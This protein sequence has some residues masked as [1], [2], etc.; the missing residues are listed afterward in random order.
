[1]RKIKSISEYFFSV[2]KILLF[3]LKIT[4]FKSSFYD[5]K[6]SNNLPSKFDYKPSFHI[7][8]SL[9]LF[10]KKKI[11]IENFSLNSL[12]KLST[13]KKVEFQNL[14]N[15]LWLTSLD[16]KTNKLS[17]QTIIENWIDNNYSFNEKTWKLDIISK[18]LI[19][20]ISSSNLTIDESS[21]NYKEKLL[22]S[23]TKQINHL[24]KNID[25]LEDDENKLICC[26]SLFLIGLTFKNQTKH[27]KLGL[28][29]LKKIIKNNFDDTRFPKSRNP[30]EMLICLKYL[31]L[32]KEWI[33]ESQNQIPDYLEEII[34]N[35]GKSYNF[36]SKNLNKLPLFNGSSEI[37]NDRFN[38]YLNYFNY[39]FKDNSK[40]K[41]GYVI[42]KNKKIVFIMDI[43][44]TPDFKHSKKYQS[45][46][47]SFEIT[48]N[49]EKLICNLGFDVNKDNKIKLLSKS[50]AAHSTL[51]LNNHS[52]CVFKKNHFF[53][54][55]QKNYL[56]KELK[57][58]KKKIT[59][60]KDFEKITASHNGYN[61]RYGYIHERSIKFI[62]KDKI[63]LGIDNLIK[64]EKASSVAY[65]IRF[66]IYPGIKIVKTQNSKSVLLSLKNGEGWKFNCHNRDI[67]IEKGIYLGNKNRII[68]N[69]NIY[70]SGMT[71]GEN[72]KIEWNFEKIS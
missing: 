63:F 31:I 22:L 4:Y 62:K 61:K 16:I 39:N 65:G 42:F 37:E 67:L 11:K 56:K 23:I 70:I 64:D 49:D 44:G 15:F 24:A 68:E 1:M 40:E 60:E 13:K 50:T 20:W 21:L 45:G 41:N 6:I 26:S 48:S 36:L 55:N 43:G 19:A 32:I 7:I 28:S 5:K 18:R 53:K 35:L 69:E 46:C 58:V 25:D 59:S 8:N 52:S 30:E 57:I 12:W 71:N 38:K 2:Y 51:Y 54:I 3:K 17:T 27:F 33:K 72:Q 10:N 29:I 14:H 66:H 34:F 9:T 47:L